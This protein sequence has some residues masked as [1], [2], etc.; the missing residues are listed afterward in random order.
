RVRVI[1]DL[2]FDLVLHAE[3]FALDDHGIDV[4]HDAIENGGG[5]RAVIV[6]DLCPV[7][8]GAVG[9]NHDRGALVALADD[10]E[11]QVCTVLVDGEIAEF[12]DDEDGGLQITADLALEVTGGLG[13]GAGG[14]NINRRGGGHGGA[15][16][17]GR[18]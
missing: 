2:P 1:A 5:Q 8:V 4:V 16:R 10:L 9:G 6:E 12:V 17:A 15:A 11:Q 13:G 18:T 3:A 7:L 14:D